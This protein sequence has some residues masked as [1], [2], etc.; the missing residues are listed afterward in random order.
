MWIK[1]ITRRWLFNVLGIV[2]LV[3]VVLIV[4]LSFAVQNYTYNGILQALNANSRELTNVFIDYKNKT[5]SDFT[6]FAYTYVENFTSKES[7]EL[8]VI[9]SDGKIVLTSTGFTPDQNQPMNDYYAALQDAEGYGSWKGKLSSG[10]RVMAVTRVLRNNDGMVVGGVRYV[11]SLENADRQIL[12]IVATLTGIGVLIILFVCISSTYFVKSI[13]NPVREINSTAK[14]IAQGDFD[15]RIQKKHNDEIGEL[16]DTINEMAIELGNSQQ[17]KNDF[18]SSVSHELRTPLTAIKGWA[19]TMQSGEIDRGTFDKGMGVIIRESERLSG[20]VEELLDF[21][22]MQSGRM[23]LMMD[24]IDILAELGE[25]VYMF[26]DRA[27]AE[28]KFLL[29]E[30]PAMLSPVLGDI[31]R[32]RQVFVN[33]IDNALKYTDEQGTVSVS[34]C[35]EDGFIKVQIVD[36]GCGIP[37]EHLPNI[38]KKFYKANHVVR[39]CG[40]GLALADEIITLHN[41]TLEVESQENL[42]T[43]VTIRIPAMQQFDNK[44]MQEVQQELPIE[45]QEQHIIDAKQID[46]TL[47]DNENQSNREV[48]ERNNN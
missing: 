6:S 32:L 19:E 24:R 10:E 9:N 22:R 13:L 45:S 14:R 40:I 39:G 41:G 25:A 12:A 36:T 42:G 18:I 1:G 46:D 48:E 26:S 28:H 47:D 43:A 21:S 17:M 3:L 38:K 5:S 8:M 20:I 27:K 34:A 29:Y 23:T 7:M 16:C 11:V 31:N 30:E 33:I 35:E 15:A 37:I 2:V 44:D 4:S